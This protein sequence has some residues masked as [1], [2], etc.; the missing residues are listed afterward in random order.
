MQTVRLQTKGADREICTD[1]VCVRVFNENV[2][3]T[4]TSLVISVELDQ[5]K[6][7]YSSLQAASYSGRA[8][9]LFEDTGLDCSTN[10]MDFF[11]GDFG[12]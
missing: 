1:A 6:A 9:S 5:C 2:L 3:S 8:F 4:R 10:P 7:R 11:K 12:P